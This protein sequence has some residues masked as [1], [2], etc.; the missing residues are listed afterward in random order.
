MIAFLSLVLCVPVSVI[1]LS[2]MGYAMVGIGMGFL[3]SIGLTVVFATM[4]QR[5][6]RGRPAG[7][8]QLQIRLALDR[9]GIYRLNVTKRSGHW[10]IGRTAKNVNVK[11]QK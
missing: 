7:Y 1:V 8:Y 10:D 11:V 9:Y 3:A 2:T 5:M 6:K 4:L